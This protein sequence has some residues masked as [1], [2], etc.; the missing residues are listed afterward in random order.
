M[1][2]KV[3]ALYADN[4]GCGDYRV[5][6]PADAVN[7]RP[8]L[9]V[10]VKTADHLDGEAL[11]TGPK[12]EVRRVDVPVGVKVI[13]FQRPMKQLL[14]KTIQWLKENRPDV[15]VVVELDD[16]LVNT[17]TS[18]IAYYNINPKTNP[19]ENTH[20][21][22]QAIALCD[23][24][25]VSTPELAR[26]YGGGSHQTF[27]IRNGVPAFMLDNWSSSVSRKA[28]PRE[29]NR[30]RVVGWAGYHATHV[31][32]LE[33]TSGALT[34]VIDG[35]RTRFRNVGPREG[36]AGALGLPNQYVEAS[37]FLPGDMYR[38]GLGELDIGIIPLADTK[39]N[40][41]KSA[42]KALEMAAAGVPMIAS[43]LPEF[44][45]LRRQG[46]PIWLVKDRRREWSGAL[47]RLLALDGNALRELA[48]SHREFIRRCG[49]VDHR[50]E[51]WVGAWQMAYRMANLRV[52]RRA[53][54]AS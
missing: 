33:V 15:G 42:L 41:A 34:D 11:F 20:W 46:M 21:L 27:I 39:F 35:D 17:P 44:E 12:C 51:E 45:L 47:R 4:S 53:V 31:G 1:T 16:D 14:V 36:V 52:I 28:T 32:D 38:V 50:A 5:R 7:R 25:T 2:L 30:E 54:A 8:D 26:R 3:I 13:S 6:Y 37:G 48:L 10:S 29:Y 49:T 22:R 19:T 40:H 24:L 43:K 9:D 23:V 18:N